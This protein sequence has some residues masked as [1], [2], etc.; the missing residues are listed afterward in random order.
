M[1]NII[2]KEDMLFSTTNY[3]DLQNRPSLN[4]VPLVG[5]LTL[6]QLD[7]YSKDEV[8]QLIAAAP[9]IE[10][11][12]EKPGVFNA[13]EGV[14]YYVGATPPY[15]IYLYGKDDEGVMRE[16]NIGESD[17]SF[18]F[19]IYQKRVDE[20]LHS[21]NKDL[22]AEMNNMSTKKQDSYT[23]DLVTNEKSIVGAINEISDNLSGKLKSQYDELKTN[24]KTLVGA[25]NELGEPKVKTL[26]DLSI[27]NNELGHKN[28]YY[29]KTVTVKGSFSDKVIFIPWM[30]TGYGGHVASYGTCKV[31]KT[32]LGLVPKYSL[33][34]F[35]MKFKDTSNKSYNAYFYIIAPPG[36]WGK[37]KNGY[38]DYKEY[39]A[40][41]QDDTPV[42]CSR[43]YM[44]RVVKNNSKYEFKW[45]TGY[46][47]KKT[48]WMTVPEANIT[49]ASCIEVRI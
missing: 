46:E 10:V 2:V 30:K 39:M 27:V 38:T 3:P 9:A 26:L 22:V 40:S 18:D 25:L 6:A 24:S 19:S 28:D 21:D 17:K 44:L 23:E 32:E 14:L 45:M 13:V 1:G 8:D 37:D 4:N 42:S 16:I 34:Y 35:D 7:L 29:G 31:D 20:D 48:T 15:T 49:S 41:F 47:Y 11:T 12:P 43:A 5:D 36:G 33:Y